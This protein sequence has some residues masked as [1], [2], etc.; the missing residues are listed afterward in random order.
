MFGDQIKKI[1]K[2]NKMS[3]IEFAEILNVSKQSVSNWENNNIEPSIEIVRTIAIKLNVSADFLLETDNRQYVYTGN[4]PI[5]F[6]THLQQLACDFE[7]INHELEKYM[8]DQD[9]NM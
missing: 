1:R 3:Q 9:S 7:K 5:E 2:S 8:N 6:V 4:L